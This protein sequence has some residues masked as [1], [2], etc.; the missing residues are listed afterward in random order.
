[1]GFVHSLHLKGDSFAYRACLYLLLFVL[2]IHLLDD[3]VY[4]FL[5]FLLL[6]IDWKSLRIWST[7][8]VAVFLVS[9]YATWVY[10]D[11][12]LVTRMDV[13][14]KLFSQG[15]LV[16]LMY[17]LG[18]TLPKHVL[19]SERGVF[20]LLLVFIIGYMFSLAYSYLQPYMHYEDGGTLL[21]VSEN[22]LTYIPKVSDA[23]KA[24]INGSTGMM[25]CFPNEYKRLHVNGGYLISTIIAYYL[26]LMAIILPLLLFNISSLK[27]KKFGYMELAFLITLSLFALYL[28]SVMGRRT[29][30]ALLLF[31]FV[32]IVLL[33]IVM[34]LK[35]GNIKYILLMIFLAFAFSLAFYWMFSDTPAVERLTQVGIHDKRFGWWYGGIQA[36]LHYPFGGGHGVFLAHNMKMAHNT[37]IDIGKDFGVIP[38]LA[39]LLLSLYF[40][41]QSLLFLLSRHTSPF[42]KQMIFLMTVS[43]FAIMML[44]PVFTSDK[45]FIA[46]I[47]FFFGVIANL[48]ERDRSINASQ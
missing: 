18:R 46:Y 33:K 21:Y 37:W 26:S 12:D 36:M 38:F 27:P 31:S 45:T 29:V 42:L 40:L 47:F 16:L 39:F 6:C 25:V 32:S 44:E 11:L 9:V 43:I 8:L 35:R 4:L 20:Y 24:L 23:P 48:N 7:F 28:A 19:Q 10:I 14:L 41:Y 2:G 17:L 13:G 3:K 34:M 22:I 30:I 5:P 1:M 15:L